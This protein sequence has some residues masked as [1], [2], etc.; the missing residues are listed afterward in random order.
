MS[1]GTTVAATPM[2]YDWRDFKT[3][4]DYLEGRPSLYLRFEGF[5][6]L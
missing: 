3:A 6:T 4:A 2:G 5:L 1:L